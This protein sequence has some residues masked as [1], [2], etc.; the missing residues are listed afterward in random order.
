MVI[1]DE[2]RFSGV[3][4]ISTVADLRPQGPPETYID[5]PAKATHV[6]GLAVRAPFG[7]DTDAIL[8]ITAQKGNGND[9]G[10]ITVA[11]G[12]VLYRSQVNREYAAQPQA[13][14]DTGD[15]A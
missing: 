14:G 4:W 10:T 3:P 13:D 8:T 2:P 6:D 9:G 5:D 11:I 12:T 7:T 15:Q 1:Y